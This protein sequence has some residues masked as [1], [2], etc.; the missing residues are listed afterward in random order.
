MAKKIVLKEKVKV[1]GMIQGGTQVNQDVTLRYKDLIE[2]CMDVPAG[3]GFTR[4]EMRLRNKISDLLEKAKKTMKLDD[5]LYAEL[6][7]AV[8]GMDGK[9]RIRDPFIEEFMADMLDNAKD[10]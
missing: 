10:A 4:Q 6:S 5:E 8:K 2:Q 9:W 7:K 1:V 3:Q